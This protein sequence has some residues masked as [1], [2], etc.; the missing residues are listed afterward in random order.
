MPKVS[1][2]QNAERNDDV[3]EEDGAARMKTSSFEREVESVRK[4]ESD[5]NGTVMTLLAGH[6][7]FRCCMPVVWYQFGFNQWAVKWRDF[8]TA[9]QKRA[10]DTEQEARAFAAAIC[11]PPIFV[12]DDARDLADCD[13]YWR[14]LAAE[15]D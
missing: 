14:K 10:F 6:P 9:I 15:L 4:F 3:P 7:Y 11:K 8:H 5:T 12:N 1:R 13:R 2:T